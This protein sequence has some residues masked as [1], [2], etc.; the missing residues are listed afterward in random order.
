[1]PETRGPGWHP[2]ARVHPDAQVDFT[3]ELGPRVDIGQGCIVGPKAVIR[4]DTYLGDNV[5]VGSG[6]EIGPD[7]RLDDGA[8]V[9]PRAELEAG[10]KMGPRSHA[11]PDSYAAQGAEIGLGCVLGPHSRLGA[12]AQLRPARSGQSTVVAGRSFVGPGSVLNGSSVFDGVHLGTG[13]V[14]VDTIMKSGSDIGDRC[15]LKDA[16]IEEK[17]ALDRGSSMDSGSALKNPDGHHPTNVGSGST[18]AAGATLTNVL[19]GNG[20]DI[21]AAAV[22][23]DSTL[24]GVNIVEPKA[25]VSGAETPDGWRFTAAEHPPAP[26]DPSLG[27]PSGCSAPRSLDPAQPGVGGGGY[28]KGEASPVRGSHCSRVRAPWSGSS[29]PGSLTPSPAI[30]SQPARRC[31]AFRALIKIPIAASRHGGWLA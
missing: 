14:A 11:A 13:V 18:I 8:R 5:S 16:S 31:A 22:V 1:M 28:T 15:A 2:D 20:A 26:P 27:D 21:G 3:A 30:P 7:V 29:G 4:A 9:G 24:G 23:D 17:C 12:G 6:A 25:H 19:A 10:V